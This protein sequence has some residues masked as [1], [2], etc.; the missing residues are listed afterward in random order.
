MTTIINRRETD[1]DDSDRLRRR[2]DIRAEAA[3]LQFQK[4]RIPVLETTLSESHQRVEVATNAHAAT[5]DPLQK[6]LK[7]LEAQAVERIQQRQPADEAADARRAEILREIADANATLEAVVEAEKVC[8]APTEREVWRLRNEVLDPKAV[9]S[10]LGQPPLAN[11]KLL[12]EQHVANERVRWLR[13]RQHAAEK[14]RA[15]QRSN[16][17]EIRADRIT[18]DLEAKMRRLAGWEA[19]VTAAA[20]ELVAA[21]GEAETV[22]KEMIDE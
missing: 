11:P 7:T 21:L 1:P 9:L 13:A 17:E 14:A 3:T 4:D 8:R 15:I 19:E 10:R 5:C 20:G 2:A 18:G 6:E 22:H 16:V 12:A